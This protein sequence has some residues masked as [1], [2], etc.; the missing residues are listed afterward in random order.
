[1]SVS[2]VPSKLTLNSLDSSTICIKLI[3]WAICTNNTIYIIITSYTGRI[4]KIDLQCSDN[5]SGH[6]GAGSRRQ[7]LGNQ[8]IFH[9]NS[10]IHT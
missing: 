5:E 1:M 6:H 10:N 9:Q 8:L 3:E 2:A 7:L 4:T